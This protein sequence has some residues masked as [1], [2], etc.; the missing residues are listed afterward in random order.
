VTKK[1]SAMDRL[2]LRPLAEPHC[3]E[4]AK[5]NL[6]EQGRIKPT[7]H[8]GLPDGELIKTQRHDW[9]LPYL[10]IVINSV[11]AA[12]MVTFGLYRRVMMNRILNLEGIHNFRDY[13]GYRTRSGAHVA[14]GVLY[15]SGQHLDATP[16]D[17]D[18]VA[19]LDLAT[20]VDLR[21]DSERQSFP[22]ARPGGFAAAVMFAAGE[23]AGG[24]HAPHVEAARAVESA[25][26]AHAAMVRL[27]ESMPFRPNLIAVFRL[28]F[29]ALAERDGSSLLHCLAGKDRTGLAVALLHDQL[30]LHPDDAMSDYMLTNTAGNMDARIA[31]GARVVRDNFGHAMDDAA[32]RTLMSVHPDYLTTAFAAIRERHGSV[33]DYAAEHLGMTPQRLRRIEEKLVTA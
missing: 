25:A 22:C 10:R 15:R 8:G 19:A 16:A 1:N 30:G 33:K 9:P 3:P 29:E 4:P 5:R 21:G 6:P 7:D 20:V 28:Y 31:A 2:N 13:G 18:V 12:C 11:D 17:L 14:S 27:Y 32:V 23:T 26:D 24:G